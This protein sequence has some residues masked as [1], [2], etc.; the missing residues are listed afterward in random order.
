MKR[1]PSCKYYRLLADEYIEGEL[2]GEVMHDFEAHIAS[3]PECRTELEELRALKEML[4]AS[5][6]EIPDGL[7]GKIMSAVRDEARPRRSC[8]RALMR[9]AVSAACAVLCLSLALIFT[10]LPLW[11]EN[12]GSDVPE[13][14]TAAG[15]N[16]EIKHDTVATV[17]AEN[18]PTSPADSVPTADSVAEEPDQSPIET[19]VLKPDGGMSEAEVIPPV[20]TSAAEDVTFDVSESPSPAPGTSA[21]ADKPETEEAATELPE[22]IET[23]A[24]TLPISADINASEDADGEFEVFPEANKAPGGDEI[25]LA[26]LVVSG[27]LAVASFIAFLISLSSIR[28]T[29]QKKNK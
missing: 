22:A 26:L 13:D 23:F 8:K 20:S 25:T 16:E 29:S 19:D 4:A 5:N 6:E 14:H 7:H 11:Q 1:T 21:E 2:S 18:A 28:K 9:T 3:C 12:T 15:T 27:L 10:V 24:E 17:D